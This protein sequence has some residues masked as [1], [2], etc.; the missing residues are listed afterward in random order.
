M[1][2]V[3]SCPV[4]ERA[5]SWQH[6]SRPVD[7]SLLS[8]VNT[9]LDLRVWICEHGHRNS[10]IIHSDT[11]SVMKINNGILNLNPYFV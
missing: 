7:V 8:N 10:P 3:R 4:V 11:M 5:L 2:A 6:S 1:H 9:S